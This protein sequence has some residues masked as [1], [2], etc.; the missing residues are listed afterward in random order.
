MTKPVDRQASGKAYRGE[1]RMQFAVKA[2]ATSPDNR[3]DP[4]RLHNSRPRS[5]TLTFASHI[6]LVLNLEG[7]VA[8]VLLLKVLGFL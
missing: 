6:S 7:A 1:V 2:A 4:K 8:S 3:H 5:P